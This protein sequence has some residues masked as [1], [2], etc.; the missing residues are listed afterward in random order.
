[1]KQKERNKKEINTIK[2]KYDPYF[3][4]ERFIFR[5]RVEFINQIETIPKTNYK[6]V[7]RE[8]LL[9]NLFLKKIRLDPGFRF[10]IYDELNQNKGI[11]RRIKREIIN[12][13]QESDLFKNFQSQSKKIDK[14]LEIYEM[15]FRIQDIGGYNYPK[16]FTSALLPTKTKKSWFHQK[17]KAYMEAG[18]KPEAYAAESILMEFI[19][20]YHQG[21]Y[22][23]WTTNPY[24]E[25]RNAYHYL[26]NAIREV[27]E[28]INPFF[29]DYIDAQRNN[30]LL[31]ESMQDIIDNLN[32]QLLLKDINEY[33]EHFQDIVK[34][35]ADLL[36]K[37]KLRRSFFVIAGILYFNSLKTKIK[38][39]YLNRFYG[40]D[41]VIEYFLKNPDFY[42]YNQFIG[43]LPIWYKFGFLP[44]FQPILEINLEK[45]ENEVKVNSA[46]GNIN[47]LLI[48]TKY[49]CKSLIEQKKYNKALQILFDKFPFLNDCKEA[50]KNSKE[51]LINLIDPKSCVQIEILF[52]LAK[53]GAKSNK[54]AIVKFVIKIY[55][56]MRNREDNT[57]NKIKFEI[58][59]SILY[60][61]VNDFN[62]ER[63]IINSLN[64]N[65]K[66]LL[67][68]KE[69]NPFEVVFSLFPPNLLTSEGFH[70]AKNKPFIHDFESIEIFEREPLIPLSFETYFIYADYR[71]II[72]QN[73]ANNILVFN[74]NFR[75]LNKL[76]N[77]CLEAQS[78]A[79]FN[80][81]V[82]LRSD[83]EESSYQEYEKERLKIIYETLA[84]PFLYFKEYGS[85]IYYLNLALKFKPADAYYNKYLTILHLFQE[86]YEKASKNLFKIYQI[87][88]HFT[89]MSVNANMKSLFQYL[90]I[91]FK[92]DKFN[93]LILKMISEPEYIKSFVKKLDIIYCDVGVSLADLGYF[94]DAIEYFNKALDIT[95]NDD[96]KAS[97]LN[98]IG[99]VYSDTIK[100]NNAIEKFELALEINPNNP[101]FW[102]NLAK[103]YQFKLN[104][105]KAKEIFLEAEKHFK[106]IDK[107]TA[108]IMYAH[109]LIMDMHIM[110]IINLNIVHEKD[111]LSH[112][113]L[114][115]QL[116]R[117]VNNLNNL[118]ENTGII[119]IELTN[120]FD[121]CFHS[122]FSKSFLDV[123][124]NV[125]PSKSKIPDE[126]WKK[127][128]LG[129]RELWKGNHMSMGHISFL[130]D[131]LLDPNSNK[132][133]LDLINALPGSITENDLRT[134]QTFTLLTRPT[135]NP[136]SHGGIL[137]KTIFINNISKII[138]SINKTLIVFEKFY[139]NK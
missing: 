60:R 124:I 32:F 99:T 57:N 118:T 130:I 23:F 55:Y 92:K 102:N 116:V 77:R 35:E 27:V 42:D 101:I 33:I 37:V 88:D 65:F 89:Y 123:L 49:L 28:N 36:N 62:N 74:E 3:L 52:L 85:A 20:E 1:M 98:N 114:A 73:N 16:I 119:F 111:A 76:L 127:L 117:N 106:D 48:L 21:Y 81:A 67:K 12:F 113:K 107:K 43:D 29:L 110:G 63:K 122:T 10:K 7:G 120:G 17:W 38:L 66:E 46:K 132:L 68:N 44:D 56:L 80:Q 128:P 18:K 94:D 39:N 34:S 58:L 90:I 104:N 75:E 11:L 61:L 9:Q 87:S 51:V 135:R 69:T 19:T 30:I 100:L 108:D 70:Y 97:L 15:R 13:V 71:K 64:V 103:M 6:E 45:F 2:E 109:S 133:I 91:W 134:I 59:R 14:D 138:E 105:I 93:K 95:Q 22:L 78:M 137:D 112:F 121:C 83:I 5:Q 40:I 115:G 84:F 41:F 72:L 24:G 25:N 4:L 53:M 79:S 139:S 8:L 54:N 86:D 50:F 82:R 136:G 126:D 96:F 31:F 125:Y 131:E 26:L 47:V 129:L